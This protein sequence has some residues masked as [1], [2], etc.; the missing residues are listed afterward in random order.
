[1]CRN[2]ARRA[3]AEAAEHRRAAR[4]EEAA[5]HR[6]DAHEALKAARRQPLRAAREAE[7]EAWCCDV[8]AEGCIK[9]SL[10]APEPMPPYSL[11]VCNA[12][13]P[14]GGVHRPDLGGVYA[15]HAVNLSMATL[16]H[17]VRRS[18]SESES[19]SESY[20]LVGLTGCAL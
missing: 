19:A 3:E 8:G 9:P 7:S 14:C 2:A 4:E 10:L 1:M 6:K 15:L 11:W 18:L 12:R 5:Q 13:C 20:K 17:S 16:M